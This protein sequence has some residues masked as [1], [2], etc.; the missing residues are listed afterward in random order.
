M[1]LFFGYLLWLK[2]YFKPPIHRCR[3]RLC[4]RQASRLSP[5]DFQIFL[6]G[7]L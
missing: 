1:L 5:C 2:R 3:Q 4:L 6:E 7:H